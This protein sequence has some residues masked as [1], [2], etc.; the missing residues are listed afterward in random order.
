MP[1]SQ[2]IRR[3]SRFAFALGWALAAMALAQPGSV[4]QQATIGGPI[5]APVPAIWAVD[6]AV[7][8]SSLPPVG[9]SLFD[10]VFARRDGGRTVTDV[11]FP[12]SRLMQRLEAEVVPDASGATPVRKVMIPLGR[13][14]QRTAAAPAY[15]AIPRV[16]V[17]VDGE[18][19]GAHAGTG[20]TAPLL[21]DRL[22]LGYQESANILE[23][24][25]YNE[26][27]GRFEFQVVRD[28]RAGGTRQVAYANRALC[29]ACH[30]NAGPIFSRALWS[31]THGNPA[32]AG[33][34]SHTT[35]ARYGV[36]LAQGIDVPY[37][38]DVATDRANELAAYQW[39]WR[40]G[41]DAG[42]DARGSAQC[43]GA[44]LVAALQ[45]RLG[46]GQGF[47]ERDTGYRGA[48]AI[49]AENGRRRWPGGLAISNPDLPNRDPLVDLDEGAI[50][51]AVAA[52]R[53]G[54]GSREALL[55]KGVN[56]AAAFDPLVP[57]LPLET[58]PLAAPESTLR[59]TVA[60]LGGFFSGDDIARLDEHLARS[61]PVPSL[62]TPALG[63]AMRST[64]RQREGVR[65]DFRCKPPQAKDDAQAIVGSL[66]VAARR[67]VGGSIDRLLVPDGAG[68]LYEVRDVDVAGGTLTITASGWTA[69]LRLARGSRF[70]RGP[71]GSRAS[72]LRLQGDEALAATRDT[73]L[74]RSFAG[75]A[76][77]NVS[78]DFAPIREAIASI[79]ASDPSG[80]EDR[81]L[82]AL[83]DAPFRRAAVLRALSTRLSTLRAAGCCEDVAGLPPAVVDTIAPIASG[84]EPTADEM[85]LHRYCALCHRSADRFPPNFLAGGS[86]EVRERIAHCAPRIHV[87]LAMWQRHGDAR[88]K[89]P[90]PPA[91][92]LSVARL[93]EVAW[94][95][96]TDLAALTT[97]IT[98]MV[99]AETGKSPNVD[100][101]LS[102]GYESLRECLPKTG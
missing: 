58:W 21:K 81:T 2:P 82:G 74:A 20:N 38:I 63:C 28:Y 59:K 33:M 50:A 102:G 7:A 14:L 92:V 96:S 35:S 9:R 55:A 99:Q 66:N 26:A 44:L 78:R 61:G 75:T 34:L 18:P 93:T 27:A 64:S 83:A 22:Y 36:E 101:L 45:Y 68:L 69:M 46:G 49:V 25:S 42:G 86:R 17:A 32:V 76:H 85:L 29:T 4:Q 13:S 70:V 73:T 37:A 52:S 88:Q 79:A 65:V 31:E 98:N 53:P 3:R 90:M 60:G 19:R 57:R 72:E 51:R 30:Q 89:T 100:E 8:E 97:Y 56:V 84:D 1:R 67:V 11:P 10:H 54:S 5:S 47:D 94:R 6:P 91:S 62:A 16:V 24:I 95:D 87:R 71:D 48:V 12:F 41:C 15:F 80:G 23:V 40:H 43:R 39:L 77:V